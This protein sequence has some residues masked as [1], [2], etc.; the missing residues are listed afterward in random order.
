MAICN[1]KRHDKSMSSTKLTGDNGY[2][3]VLTPPGASFDGEAINVDGDRAAAALAVALGARALVILSDVP[4]LLEAFPDES[5]LISNIQ[6]AKINDY[7]RYAEGR[8]K[9]KVMGAAEAVGEGVGRV[10]FAD[11][12]IESPLTAALEGGGTHIE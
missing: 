2:Q 5:S 12:R 4:G 3:P 9:K 7:M 11:G 1:N 10:I 6:A 8:M